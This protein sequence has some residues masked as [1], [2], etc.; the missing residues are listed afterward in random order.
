MKKVR[1]NTNLLA[2]AV[3]WYSLATILP[4]AFLGCAANSGEIAGI[5]S[6]VDK[7]TETLDNVQTK[8]DAVAAAVE[9][10]S[11]Q[12]SG[13]ANR[14]QNFDPWTMRALVIGVGV[15]A[16]IKAVASIRWIYRMNKAR[17]VRSARK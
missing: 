9:S 15:Y 16:A 14:V 8:V 4:P 11:Q 6:K 7:S 13:V 1:T 2:T 17:A 10:N 12:V 5:A 3:G